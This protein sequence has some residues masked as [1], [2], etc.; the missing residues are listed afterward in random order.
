MA[1]LGPLAAHMPHACTAHMGRTCAPMTHGC[2][3]PKIQTCTAHRAHTCSAHRGH[4]CITSLPHICSAHRSHACSTRTI[5]TTQQTN[6]ESSSRIVAACHSK[7]GRSEETGTT[8]SQPAST[9]L[10]SSSLADQNPQPASTS[11]DSSALADQ[12]SRPA[13]TSLGDSSLA[14]QIE[15][16]AG[17]LSSGSAPP[18]GP[19]SSICSTRSSAVQDG[20]NLSGS[21]QSNTGGVGPNFTAM[22]DAWV[23]GAKWDLPLSDAAVFICWVQISCLQLPLAYGGASIFAELQGRSVAELSTDEIVSAALASE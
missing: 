11:L 15:K 23:A 7:E 5:I 3:A 12:N 20:P 10:D 2:I 13:S 1:H 9:S 22:M 4:V 14:D 8:N 17:S 6:V 18:Q 16:L 21:T 19:P